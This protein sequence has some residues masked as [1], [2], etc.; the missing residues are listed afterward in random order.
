MRGIRAWAVGML[1][2][3]FFGS[4]C[5]YVAAGAILVSGGSSGGG[6]KKAPEVPPVILLPDI[7][8][9]VGTVSVDYTLQDA[10]EDGVDVQVAYSTDSG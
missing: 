10:N 2:I 9:Q 1:V 5:G 4:G 7:S 3:L 6:K 8:R